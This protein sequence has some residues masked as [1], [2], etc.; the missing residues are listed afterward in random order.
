[1]NTIV[2]YLIVTMGSRVGLAYQGYGGVSVTK[3]DGM[4][5]CLLLKSAVE[6]QIR[7][8][9]NLHFDDNEIIVSCREI[10]N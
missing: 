7:N 10:K 6:S 4:E 8:T 1:M 9:D 2:V 5:S 3:T